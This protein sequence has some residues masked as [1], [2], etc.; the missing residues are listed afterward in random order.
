ME[1]SKTDRV[2][3]IVTSSF[4]ST[5]S[6]RVLGKDLK[7][8]ISRA[9]RDALKAVTCTVV[10]RQ[11]KATVPSPRAVMAELHTLIISIELGYRNNNG[12]IGRTSVSQVAQQKTIS[13][14]NILNGANTR[15]PRMDCSPEISDQHEYQPRSRLSLRLNRS[16]PELKK[17]KPDL[18]Y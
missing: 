7:L 16:P 1:H 14:S 4:G 17:E 12:P 5:S 6:F 18:S 3:S 15:H 10:H 2:P 9:P 13:L 11:K 8:V